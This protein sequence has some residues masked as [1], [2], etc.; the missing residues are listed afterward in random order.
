M[1]IPGVLVHVLAFMTRCNGLER[2]AIHF[3]GSFDKN[4]R[5]KKEARKFNSQPQAQCGDPGHH[6]NSVDGR[7]A[8]MC[9]WAVPA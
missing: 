2:V 7:L 6:V 5:P 8:S 1:V 4:W 3:R 9:R